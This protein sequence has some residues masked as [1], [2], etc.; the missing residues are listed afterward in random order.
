M[1][2]ETK[3]ILAFGAHP[4]DV[5]F[6]CGGLLIKEIK[7]GAE[8]KIVI[9][10]L[11]EAGT[12]GTP[13]SRKA[14]AEAA[15]KFIGAEIEFIDMGGDC[16]IIN[17]PENTIHLAEIIRTYQPDIVMAPSLTENQHPD[18]RVL[19]EMVRAACRLARYG[20]LQEIKHLLVHSIDALYFYPSS[21]EFDA[22]PDIVVDVSA[23]YDDWVKAMSLHESQ[24]KTR[25]YLNLVTSKAQYV[26]A[27][28]GVKYAI[29]LWA[30]DPVRVESLS[31]LRSSRNY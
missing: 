4:D 15:A 24:M 11:G 1:N 3:K 5:E 20:G 29:G 22:Q 2:K 23:H 10:S 7:N 9:G 6:G 14:E 13:E 19:A 12:N 16:H 28:V 26:G 25:G 17:T 8:V 21:A 27:S 30:N 31:H 18:H